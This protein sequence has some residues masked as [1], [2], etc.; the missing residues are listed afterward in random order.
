MQLL[1]HVNF[2]GALLDAGAKA[3]APVQTLVPRNERAAEGVRQW[4]HY[5]A[6]QPGFEEQVFFLELAA[7]AG[8]ETET[9]L[10]SA[11]GSLGASLRFSI[12]QLPCFTIW[13]NT[14]A[15][16]DGY[17]TGLEPGTNYPNPRSFEQ[18]Q[19]RVVSLKPGESRAFD[20]AI[21]LHPDAASVQA[22]EQAIAGLQA[23][24]A[25]TIHLSPQPTFCAS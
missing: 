18:R 11:H 16:W 8:G 10:R 13:K 9:L 1:Y 2:G 12:R 5:A 22:A 21:A 3:V 19:G 23:K 7:D 15:A 20:L 17:V 25:P 14:A 6:E 24:T 4:D